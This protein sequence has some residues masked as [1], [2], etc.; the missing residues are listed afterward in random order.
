SA[1]RTLVSSSMTSTRS[2]EPP[3]VGAAGAAGGAEASG[4]RTVT[5]VPH[6]SFGR[7]TSSPPWRCT[8]A[9]ATLSP[10]PVPCGPLVVKNGPP[11]RL[12]HA[13][14][15]GGG[16]AVGPAV[17]ARGRGAVLPALAKGVEGL[18]QQ[19][20]DPPARRRPPPRHAGYGAERDRH[21][22]IDGVHLRLVAPARP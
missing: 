16:R 6:P 1:S 11:P 12:A 5:T 13:R 10:S 21:V 17:G 9:W 4:S 18:K 22:E 15:G 14:A 3:G 2:G 7:R 19:V 20:H 8:M